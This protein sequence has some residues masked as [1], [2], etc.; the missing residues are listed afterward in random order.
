MMET[1]CEKRA[2]MPQDTTKP[3]LPVPQ[4]FLWQ[5]VAYFASYRQERS[6]T[7]V[8]VFSNSNAYYACPRCKATL[9]REFVSFCD[10][11]G[12]SLSWKGY[13]KAKIIH[14]GQHTNVHT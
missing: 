11:C 1:V 7:E 14:P 9:D 2:A 3:E 6:I 12:Q 5:M 8:M 13:R 4:A 10:R